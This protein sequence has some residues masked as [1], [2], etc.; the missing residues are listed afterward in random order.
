MKGAALVTGA[1]RGIGRAIA[2]ALA[3]RGWPV[4]VHYRADLAK[5]RE[6]A[7]LIEAEG[8]R[9]ALVQGDL[10]EAGAQEPILAA[11]EEA[12]G[13]LALFVQNAGAGPERR[14]DCLAEEAD[15]VR[16]MLA[17][18]LEGP[19]LLACR[20]AERLLARPGEARGM[21]WVTS[22]SAALA[23]TERAG[24]CLAK[25][26]ATMGARLLALRLAPAGIPVWEVRPGIIETD[27]TAPVIE[28]Y[29]ERAAAGLVPVGRTGLPEEVGRVVAALVEEGGAYATGAVVTVDGGLSLGRL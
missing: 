3:K 7:A 10:A 25:A 11:A 20:A 14:V 17:V 24:Y 16:R 21:V 8:G 18:N 28:K 26:G 4:A 23:S 12:L 29:R 22:V 2:L 1:G 27:M 13:P 6:A 9:A 5:A 19:W 15:S